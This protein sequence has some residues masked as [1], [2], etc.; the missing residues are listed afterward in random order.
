VAILYKS[1][2]ADFNHLGL[3]PLDDAVSILVTEERNGMF[4]LEMKYPI[5]GTRINEIKLDRLIKA[6][7]GHNLKGQLFKII[8]ITKPTDGII[9]VN[10]EHV[11][12]LTQDLALKPIVNYTGSAS[13][14]LNTW[15]NNLVDDSPF[16]V[17]SDITTTGSGSWSIKEVKNAREAL[18][19]VSGSI[20]ET[21]GGEYRFDNYSIRLMAQRGVNSGALIAY[22]RNL[23][24]L[25]QEES[26]AETF[27][28]IYPYAIYQDDSNKE[29]LLT[30]P[31][32]F[33]DS[34]YVGNYAR[35][36]ILP[37]DFSSDEIKDVITLRSRANSYINSNGVGIPKVNMQI[38]YI[39]LAK[40][41]DYK[42]LAILEEVNLCD[43]IFVYFEQL[44]VNT[45]AKIIK[46]VW[47]DLL[48]Q[49]DSIEVGEAKSSLSNSI[50]S[51]VD[52][53]LETIVKRVNTIQ[54]TADGLNVI[55]R[56]LEEP[57]PGNIGDLW[58]E[59]DGIYENMYQWDGSIW[60]LMLSTRDLDKVSKEVEKHTDEIAIVT[61]SAN[62]AVAKAD[63][64]IEDAGF[65][66]IDSA[67]AVTDALEATGL[68]NQAKS[69]AGIAITNAGTA[70][71]NA[72]IAL[73]GFNDLN[74]GVNN[75]ILNSKYIKTLP[76]SSGTGTAVLMT[77]ETIPYYRVTATASYI[78]TYEMSIY[79]FM[80]ANCIVGKE[81][82]IGVDVRIP[83][84]GS[85]G[86]DY[87]MTITSGI[88]ANVWTRI[89]HTFTY[90]TGYFPF[91]N[92]YSG[93][94]LDYRLWKLETGN[95]GSAW[96]PSPEDVQTQITDINGELSR[97]ASQASF[98]TLNGTVSNQ[99]TLIYQSQTAIGLKADRTVTDTLNSTVSKHTTDIKATA[100]GLA[101]KADSSVVN[102]LTGTVNTH[103]NQI[104][105]NSTAINARLTSSQVDTLVAGKNYVTET[106][107]NAT[108][109]TLSASITKVSTD[110]SNIE[111][112][113]T[114][115]L[116]RSGV[117]TTNSSYILRTYQ[118]AK[119]PTGEEMYTLVVKG[120]VD[121]SVHT[122]FY[123]NVYDGSGYPSMV[124]IS[125][126]DKDNNGIYRKTFM[127]PNLVD[128]RF[129]NMYSKPIGK[130][131]NATVEWVKLVQGEKTSKDWSPAPE[132]MATLEKFTTLNATV[133]GIQTT[134]VAKAEQTQ[135]TQLATQITTK[136]ESSTYNSK[137]TQLDSAIN[138]RVESSKVISQ[139]NI[140]TEGI[141][142]QGK[143]IQLDGDVTMT[144]AFINNIK[145]INISA[146]RITTGTLNASVVNLINM[147][148]SKI[149]TGT[150]TGANSAWNLN[151]GSMN[152]SNP[153]TGDNLI[154]DQGEI[155]F[156]NSGQTRY[157]R[158]NAE[159]LQLVP[160][161]GNTGTSKNTSLYLVG[162]GS[163][164]YQ[165]IQFLEGGG[166]NYS[167]R[168]EAEG[169]NIRALVSPSGTFEVRANISKNW[170]EVKAGKLTVASNFSAATMSV[171][172]G[173]LETERY[174]DRSIRL[175]PTGTGKVE[176]TDGT[177]WW[178]VKAKN[179]ESVSS[180]TL[181]TNISAYEG[182]GLQIIN[183]L[184]VVSYDM[185]QD[186]SNGINDKKV[187]LISEDSYEVAS[188]DGLAI[189][190]YMLSIFNTKAIQEIYKEFSIEIADLKEEIRIL[191]GG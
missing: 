39:D 110:L 13:Q 175:M 84:D 86:F 47:N 77:N 60:K 108:S 113:E 187:G 129:I 124:T 57:V 85:V 4:E 168:L 42:D 106:V 31:E 46:T 121:S 191:K 178:T 156:Q 116:A 170:N 166:N 143:R 56:G 64:A 72:Q 20:L 27:T 146:D 10:A 141:L 79:N 126:E 21:Y 167:Q 54:L 11:S 73:D 28:S 7:A 25:T 26:I 111:I 189:D 66:Q 131:V 22:G 34:E 144:T 177:Y 6:D 176:T 169:G 44:D 101:L 181:K 182:S 173:S 132:D 179:F 55:Y 78:S 29:V 158:Y 71:T 17:A 51:T 43:N 150:I 134:V 36:K 149:V 65:A 40:T 68:A 130:Y 15:N 33:V 174:G 140:S 48:E 155:E 119:K 137:M 154:F 58:Y 162:G 120:L 38:K 188:S 61:Q 70:I 63:Q 32:Y 128:F 183:S 81:Y 45:S 83:N 50:N 19:G 139:I 90:V 30:L 148:A 105:I 53:K 185:I 18:G 89:F 91:G 98:D 157:L 138:L 184:N 104:G 96:S 94:Q 23:V 35:R 52:G 115:I 2:E 69:D 103:S 180:R 147:N 9:T 135:V 59:P 75:L 172:A 49:Y 24:D 16:I 107:L 161:S 142:L 82:T 80:S 112:S 5:E 41:L 74:I 87:N 159:G 118:F 8:R 93:Q 97:K 37:V 3:G 67:K 1:N 122:G 92:I 160:G 125:E 127:M 14:A 190:T 152:F 102:T 62:D 151:T 165:Y 99:S 163:G 76:N 12:Y 145:A 186:I 133:D 88:K 117:V 100:D 95:L 109:G 171:T 136:V 123:F 114:N 153:S 164:S